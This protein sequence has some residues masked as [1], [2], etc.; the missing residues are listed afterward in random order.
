M[1]VGL[2][3]SDP[4]GMEATEREMES[5]I[6]ELDQLPLV[7]LE[8]SPAPPAP[9]GTRAGDATVY[10]SLVLGLAGAPAVRSLILLVQDWLARR[11]S[12]TV[13]LRIGDDEL[14]MEAGSPADR[15]RIAEAF[16]AHHASTDRPG[17]S[18]RSGGS[19]GSD[20]SG[21]SDG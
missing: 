3:F 9:Q 4:D 17:G 10:S 6:E 19:E 11:T 1:D 18:D 12:G 14:V 8:H 20:R 13:T 5:L 7:H 16:L 2:I 15:R 21:G